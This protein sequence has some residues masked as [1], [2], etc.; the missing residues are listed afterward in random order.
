MALLWNKVS[1][2]I[3]MN[4]FLQEILAGLQAKPKYLLSKYFYD[5]LGDKIF[6]QIMASEEYYLTKCELEIFEQQTVQLCNT[7][8][9]GFNSFD[10]VE[11]GAGDATKSSLLLN[12]LVVDEVEF[13]YCPI[14]ISK[15]TID[16]LERQLPHKIPGLKVKGFNG[17]YFEMLEQTKIFSDRRKVVL[18]LGSN[19]G[20]MPIADA[21]AFCKHLRQNLSKTDLLLIGF[22][23]KKHPKIILDA[24]N[25][26]KG[27]TK[28]FN[29]NLL[30]RIN[31]ELEAN[32]DVSNFEHYPVYNP[33]TGAC[34]SY[35]LS[36]QDQVVRIG[37]ADF[38]NFKQNE[39]IF[40]EISQKYNIDEIETMAK[41]TGFKIVN[42]FYDSKNWFLDTVWECV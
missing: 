19:I 31:K 3:S 17:E 20:N 2:I 5:D 18:F 6:Q 24:Y 16:N 14:D 25:D 13:N 30:T 42:N 35:L 27:Y 4:K 33:L 32:F 1:K 37:E 9:N 28:A 29:L 34:Q 26:K 11:L 15:N 12:Q 39:A 41:E 36:T 23:L 21:Y 8:K 7:L 22:D 10:L 40:M 38:I